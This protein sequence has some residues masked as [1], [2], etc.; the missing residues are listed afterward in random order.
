VLEV[1]VI[2]IDANDLMKETAVT[3][4][5][6]GLPLY[7]RNLN[8]GRR[9]TPQ[10]WLYESSDPETTL[11][12]WI[13]IMRRAN[14]TSPLGAEFTEFDLK[15][16]EKFGPQGEIPSID[17][18]E[19]NDVIEPLYASSEYDDAQQ[20]KE[21]FSLADE[22][23]KVIFGA[24]DRL[25]HRPLS[26]KS[27]LEDM[28]RRGTLSTN[29]GY[30][31]FTRR[32]RVSSQEVQD[33]ESLAAYAYPAIILFRHYY[34]KLRPVWMFP[35]SINL[36]ETS[37]TSPIQN[38][39]QSSPLEW[40]R[41]YCTP[42]EGFDHVKSVLRKQWPKKM[43]IVG[44]DTTKMDAHMRPAQ[45]QIVYRIV[46]W[47][48]QKQYWPA[49]ERSIM[50][51]CD[52]DLLWKFDLTSKKVVKL[53]GTHGLASGSGWT[54]L[55]ETVL[56]LFMAYIAGVEGQGIGD[57]FYWISDMNADALV[58][59]LKKFGLPA[60]PSKQSVS[61]LHLTFLQ[62]YFHQGFSSRESGTV[63]GAYYPTI[64]ALCSMLLPERFHDPKVWSVEMF[65]LRNFMILENCVD[66]PC[67]DEFVKFVVRGHKEMSSF[68]K[69]TAEELDAINS[70]ARK[71][72]GLFPNYNQEKLG[73]SLSTFTS[74]RVAKYQ[75]CFPITT[76]R[77]WDSL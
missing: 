30:P 10:S 41:D 36:I 9:A 52:I 38:K 44:G 45:L 24:A 64:R 55:S 71:V 31:R 8:F 61:D 12:R 75:D 22:F 17:S 11:H 14:N 68:A 21:W 19:C 65:C 4:L 40:V 26:Y 42:W 62:R 53:R 60:N 63:A 46:R 7:L 54:Q 57:D 13:P 6:I 59:F 76:R 50:H 23:G 47:L 77:S 15:Q 5:G 2:Q 35:M 25:R 39:L 37:F 66:D 51:I 20:L 69:K 16:L 1:E 56:Q 73:Q 43:P 72:P 3:S 33:A 49:L 18:S 28:S 70:E 29:S 58:S 32:R 27:V 48:F 67:F 74:I 34:G